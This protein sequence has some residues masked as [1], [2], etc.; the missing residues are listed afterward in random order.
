MDGA[1]HP[2]PPAPNRRHVAV[3]SA[4]PH[5]RYILL[6]ARGKEFL[7]F[8]PAAFLEQFQFETLC[9]LNHTA[10]RFAGKTRF[11]RS[12]LAG[13]RCAAASR[14]TFFKVETFYVSSQ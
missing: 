10:C 2:E 11:S 1:R 13:R 6:K 8:P 9:V 5:A 7:L 4:I 12:L 3:M 14:F